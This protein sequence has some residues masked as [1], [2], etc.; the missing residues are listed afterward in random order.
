MF[1]G[2][3]HMTLTVPGD[4]LIH[5]LDFEGKHGLTSGEDL[6]KKWYAA[7]LK[8]WTFIVYRDGNRY[9]R[10]MAKG[11]YHKF[12]NGGTQNYDDFT[13]TN[14]IE[15]L[16]MFSVEIGINPTKEKLTNIE[17]GVNVILPFDVRIVL[18]ALLTYKGI[19][20]QRPIENA[21]YFQCKTG[22]FIIKCYDK[23]REFKLS[24]NVL[25]FEIKVINKRFLIDKGIEITYLSDLLNYENY[26]KLGRLLKEYFSAIL[27][28][29]SELE[30]SSFSNKDKELIWK[31]GNP[32]YWM[33]PEKGTFK[34]KSEYEAARKRQSREE[35]RFRN[36][37]IPDWYDM[38]VERIVGKWF[39]LTTLS[40]S[41]LSQI[42]RSIE[43]WQCIS[44]N[45]V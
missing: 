11:S 28:K 41:I 31:G 1:D 35:L 16:N 22:E 18:N 19:A 36:F 14:L 29:N 24:Q 25:R 12:F 38:L 27:F 10:V 44:Y 6:K 43:N 2:A 13:L 3:K 8:G 45:S 34:S 20:F 23:G 37:N 32:I 40:D 17:F 39:E 26:P 21:N 4:I 15:A 7:K 30:I 9:G 5:T 42:Q 33:R